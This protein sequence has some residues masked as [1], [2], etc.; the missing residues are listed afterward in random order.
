MQGIDNDLLLE[1]YMTAGG[2]LRTCLERGLAGS[3]EGPSD[4]L[5]EVQQI[6]RLASYSDLMVRF[7]QSQTPYISSKNNRRHIN[8]L[9]SVEIHTCEQ[10]SAMLRNVPVEIVSRISGPGPFATII[11]K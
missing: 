4:W 5:Q 8:H 10:D 3:P 2:V 6:L 11:F 1:W 9:S 7:P